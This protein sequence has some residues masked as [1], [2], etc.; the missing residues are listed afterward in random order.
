MN[1]VKICRQLSLERTSTVFPVWFVGGQGDSRT[2]L[3]LPVGIPCG[4]E[5]AV[6]VFPL[7]GAVAPLA[8]PGPYSFGK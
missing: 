4:F 8:G 6:P 2:G 3:D 1:S 7:D 5:I